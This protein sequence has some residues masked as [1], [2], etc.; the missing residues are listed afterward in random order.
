MLALAVSGT[1]LQLSGVGWAPTS[2]E[3]VNG[4]LPP[5]LVL[6]GGTGTI[7]GTLTAAGTYIFTVRAL[8]KSRVER[9]EFSVTV[10]PAD[11]LLATS[12]K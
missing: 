8:S 12:N 3:V 1:T 11:I 5:N 2:W 6:H 9:Q 10:R 7:D 4:E